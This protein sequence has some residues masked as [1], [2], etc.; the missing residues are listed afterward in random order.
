MTFIA[1]NRRILP[2]AITTGEFLGINREG[3]PAETRSGL[4]G[5]QQSIQAVDCMKFLR[6]GGLSRSKRRVEGINKWSGN[7]L[8]SNMM[9]GINIIPVSKK[10]IKSKENKGAKNRHPFRPACHSSYY[11]TFFFCPGQTLLINHGILHQG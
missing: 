6:Q 4:R 10:V 5:A 2:H 11:C 1:R 7:E 8:H 3:F 9:E